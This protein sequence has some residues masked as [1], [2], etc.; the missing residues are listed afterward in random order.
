V[1][2]TQRST[3][4]RTKIFVANWAEMEAKGSEE[5]WFRARIKAEKGKLEP[6]ICNFQFPK[7]H[8]VGH[9]SNSIRRIGGHANFATDISEL[10]HIDNVKESYRASNGVQ[11]K[12][13]ML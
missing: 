7:M 3:N 10:L 4:P 2:G 9:V 6:A 11:Y 5:G 12:E 13:Q 8:I 1:F